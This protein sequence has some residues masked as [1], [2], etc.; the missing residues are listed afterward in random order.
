MSPIND[1]SAAVDES[2]LQIANADIESILKEL[3]QEEKVALLTGMTKP[4]GS[5]YEKQI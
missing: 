5:C 3:T 1:S 4:I 2:F